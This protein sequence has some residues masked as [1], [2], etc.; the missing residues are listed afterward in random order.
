[1]DCSDTLTF[2]FERVMRLYNALA[3]TSDLRPA[4]W[5]ALRFFATAPQEERTIS[6]FA[7]A[8]ASTMGTTSITVTALVNRGFLERSHRSR[9]V[10]LHLTEKGQHYVKN[11]DPA[12]PV[13]Q[14][15]ASLAPEKRHALEDALDQMAASLDADQ[16][17]AD[18]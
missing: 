9:N 8:R 13:S 18:V 10:G 5:Q 7:R 4:Q 12:K 6:A 15:L 16:R 17:R 14:T 11:Y 2:K 1:M 3:Y